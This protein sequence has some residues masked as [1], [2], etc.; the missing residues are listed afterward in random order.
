MAS[1]RLLTPNFHGVHADHTAVHADHKVPEN[2]GGRHPS[3]SRPKASVITPLFESDRRRDGK[4]RRVPVGAILNT[5]SGN[6]LIPRAVAR[7]ARSPRMAPKWR[8]YQP[9]LAATGQG[10]AAVGRGRVPCRGCLGRTAPRGAGAVG[11]CVW[12]AYSGPGQRPLHHDRSR[13]RHIVAATRHRGGPSWLRADRR[14]RARARPSAPVVRNWATSPGDQ[15]SG[16]L[17]RRRHSLW[18]SQARCRSRR[19]GLRGGAASPRVPCC[20]APTG[21]RRRSCLDVGRR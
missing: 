6:I 3:P 4:C 21:S 17:R 1:K 11:S 2:G 16:D 14:C 19:R 18:V 15:R 13:S 7:C 10:G 8:P 5:Q 9:R 12:S 20:T